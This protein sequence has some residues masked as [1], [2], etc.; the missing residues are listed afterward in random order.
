MEGQPP[1]SYTADNIIL[2]TNI[3]QIFYDQN[4]TGIQLV[5]YFQ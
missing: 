4:C 3:Q 1:F 5:Q 2:V